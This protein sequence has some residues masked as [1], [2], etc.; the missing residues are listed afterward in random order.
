MTGVQ[1][2]ALPISDGVTVLVDGRDGTVIADPTNDEVTA[3]TTREEALR[4]RA[5]SVTGPGRLSDGT[6]VAL[7]ANAGNEQDAIA[8]AA[9]GAEGIGLFRTELLFLDRHSEPSVEEQANLYQRVFDAMAGRK[10]VL[11][12]L[13]A[14]SDKPVPFLNS[15]DEENPALGVRGW[16]LTRKIV[17]AH[18]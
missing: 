16:R 5:A 2:C 18:V 11:R 1:T 3:R 10:V 13:D 8:G 17:R 15:I 4:A 6:P 9:V 12:T 7:M 14:G